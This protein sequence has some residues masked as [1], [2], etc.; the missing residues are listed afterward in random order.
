MNNKDKKSFK[1]VHPVEVSLKNE[2]AP[3]IPI[4]IINLKP[5]FLQRVLVFSLSGTYIVDLK[6]EESQ[7]ARLSTRLLPDYLADFLS[8]MVKMTQRTK[9]AKQQ[10]QPAG[11]DLLKEEEIK[12]A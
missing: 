3:N 12:F 11:I 1:K 2:I 7:V 6:D 5:S 9:V 8:T 4:G 10:P